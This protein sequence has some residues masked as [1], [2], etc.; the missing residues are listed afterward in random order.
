MAITL[1]SATH[2]GQVSGSV[3]V[4]S[5]SNRRL[6]VAVTAE[7]NTLPG[8]VRL[9]GIDLS[10]IVSAINTASVGNL[11]AAYELR[12][13]QMPAAGTY[14]L[15]LDP[16]A[17]PSGGHSLAALFFTDASQTDVP[18][19]ASIGTDTT[20]LANSTQTLTATSP[21]GNSIGIGIHC[22]GS[23]APDEGVGGAGWTQQTRS[24]GGSAGHSTATG[25]FTGESSRSVT[26]TRATTWNRAS[27]VILFVPEVAS[28]NNYTE[29]PN[30]TV[31]VSDTVTASGAY[32]RALT[33]TVSISDTVTVSGTYAAPLAET[34]TISDTVAE[35]AGRVVNVPSVPVSVILGPS[36]SG[37]KTA[38]DLNGEWIEVTVDGVRW[39]LWWNDQ[40]TRSN[41]QPS[42]PGVTFFEVVLPPGFSASFA[43]FLL[44]TASRVNAEP[45]F[46]GVDFPT[47]LESYNNDDY[48]VLIIPGTSVDNQPGAPVIPDPTINGTDLQTWPGTNVTGAFGY[49]SEFANQTNVTV[50]DA[51]TAVGSY[52]RG[53]TETVTVTDAVTAVVG[54]QANLAETVGVSDAAT[55]SAGVR[56]DISETVTVTDAV[57]ARQGF[58][59]PLTDT[60]TVTDAV[61]AAGAYARG[62]TDT[63]TVTDAA[64]GTSEVGRNLADTVTVSETLTAVVGYLAPLTD[65][66]TVSD[67]VG[68]AGAYA[69]GLTDTVTVSD[70]TTPL[71]GFRAPLT[72]SVAVTDALG[73][74][75]TYSAPLTDTVTVSDAISAQTE[76]GIT[77][78]ETVTVTDAV[79]AVVS[80]LADVSDAVTVSDTLATLQGYRVPLT[81]SVAVSDNLAP[82]QG[83][84][85]PLTD[86]VEISDAVNATTVDGVSILETVTVSETLT[87]VG[88][89]ARGLTDSVTVSDTAEGLAGYAA[90]L[91]DTVSVADAAEQSLGVLILEN[92]TVSEQLDA[93]G[94]YSAALSDTVDVSA[95]V[96]SFTGLD[97]PARILVRASVYYTRVT[98]ANVVTNSTIMQKTN[99][100]QRLEGLAGQQFDVILGVFEPN[101]APLDMTGA[102]V[103]VYFGAIDS[104]PAVTLGVGT[105]V[106]ITAEGAIHWTLSS[107]QSMAL[108]V[109]KHYYE[110]WDLD[111]DKP[112]H[113]PAELILRESVRFHP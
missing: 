86:T 96:N 94:V 35:S 98:R 59:A 50:T 3:T 49:V 64:T 19:G 71:Q 53:L 31:T 18:G 56:R 4:P 97:R 74:V 12:E 109:G 52:A 46:N 16:G 110:V 101:G 91:T 75:G 105:G 24:G 65:T 2:V 55:G 87:V 33:E 79:T 21:T 108:G 67:A 70:A 80:Y 38:A 41:T 34:V 84:R 11:S 57:T 62:L 111:E 106:E 22:N 40:D 93:V 7:Y 32:S 42:A 72:D 27:G 39:G 68:A 78:D 44:W 23:N 43:A 103:A 5:G 92:V 63:V 60:V 89:Y 14:T 113:A 26:F 90:G 9:N 77:I 76:G 107:A 28:G 17:A 47:T 6:I 66:V 104:A 81:D 45:S 99:N 112:L 85:V 36:D 69:R 54:Y 37:T 25:S 51:V 48:Q 29:T 8:W 73:A 10:L 13:A 102:A 1:V 61:G 88:S 20:T 30:E 58:R 15:E 95:S 83:Y 82:L 100:I